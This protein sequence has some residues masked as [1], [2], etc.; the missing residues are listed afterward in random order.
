MGR[1]HARI[2]RDDIPGAELVAVCDANAERLQSDWKAAAGNIDTGAEGPL[3]LSGIKTFTDSD[4]LLADPE[5]EA[6]DISLPTFLHAPLT[7][8]ALQAGKH[9]L[10]EKPMALTVADSQ[11]MI[12]AAEDAGK[13]LVI[14][15]CLRFWPEY[16]A[17]KDMI[18]ANRYGAVLSADLRR[19]SPRPAWSWNNWTTQGS[20]SGGAALDLHIHDVDALQWFFGAPSK[21]SSRGLIRPDGAI[22]HIITQYLY[23]S[24]PLVLAEGCWDLPPG[25]PYSMSARLRF[26]G[27]T[28]DF[29]T[30]QSPT[31]TVYL[32][33]GGT[34][35]PELPQADAYVE[36]LRYFIDCVA[37][38][39]PPLRVPP[40]ES[41]NAVRIVQA[42]I[43]SVKAGGEMMEIT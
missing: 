15:H 21:V 40:V 17:L 33:E 18:D 26:E 32:A 4:R 39:R 43:A 14:G 29:N 22:G 24:I 8:K 16:V 23:P 6:V 19:L 34:E 5:I 2:Y 38:G 9:V 12:A 7:I 42:E 10:C 37:T 25:F 27:A 1:T 28:A 11:R 20:K 13:L 3:D 36:E 35:T 30:T 41:A 31:V